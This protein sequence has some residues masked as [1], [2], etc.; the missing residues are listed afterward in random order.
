MSRG[1]MRD[2]LTSDLPYAQADD[3]PF[4]EIGVARRIA[5]KWKKWTG[6]T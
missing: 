1:G 6:F 4:A 3:D 5:E 2:E